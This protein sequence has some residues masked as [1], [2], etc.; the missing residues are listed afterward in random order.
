MCCTLR[1]RP[2]TRMQGCAAKTEPGDIGEGSSRRNESTSSDEKRGADSRE[3]PFAWHTS[4]LGTAGMMFSGCE[5]EIST[6]HAN[7]VVRDSR[8]PCGYYYQ[9]SVAG[10][11]FHPFREPEEP[12]NPQTSLKFSSL[13]RI[14]SIDHMGQRNKTTGPFDCAMVT[15]FCYR[16]LRPNHRNFPE[17]MRHQHSERACPLL[18]SA[19]TMQSDYFRRKCTYRTGL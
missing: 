1:H 18:F 11:D 9:G 3:S 8:L 19:R 2:N 4:Q 16:F 7:Q 5:F 15:G 10:Y 12:R 13:S 6:Y 14:S 17:R